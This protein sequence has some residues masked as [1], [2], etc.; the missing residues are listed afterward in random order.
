[1][2]VQAQAPVAQFTA[3]RDSGCAPLVVNFADISTGNP[4]TWE[5]DFGNGNQSIL[6]NASAFF[7]EEREYTI[8]LIVRNANGVDTFRKIIK[9]FG[10]PSQIRFTPNDTSGCSPFAINFSATSN[11]GFGATSVRYDWRFG[12]GATAI[13]ANVAHTYTTNGTRN[14]FLRATNDKGCASNAPQQTRI[15]IGAGLIVNFRDSILQD[16]ALP[17]RAY[18]INE[19]QT[20]GNTFSWNLGNGILSNSIDTVSRLFTTAG[21]YD[22]KLVA[23]NGIGCKDSITRS[24]N[25]VAFATSINGPDSICAGSSASFSYTSNTTISSS[26]WRDGLLPNPANNVASFSRT[27]NTPGNYSI[28]LNVNYGSCSDQITKTLV[29]KPRPSVSWRVDGDS[30][31]CSAPLE[32]RFV[33]TSTSPGGMFY[34][35]S[36]GPSGATDIVQQPRYLYQ[37]TGNF[38]VSLT[39][40]NSFN[41]SATLTRANTVR[42]QAPTASIANTPAGGCAPF[43]FNA[44]SGVTTTAVD[45]IVRYSWDFGVPG[46]D[47]DTS[48]LRNPSFTYQ[49]SGNYTA[50]LTVFTQTGCSIRVTRN[51]SIGSKATFAIQ[52]TP[53]TSCPD[54]S[55][56]FQIVG[57]SAGVSGATPP[58]RYSW[59]FGDG[60]PLYAGTTNAFTNFNRTYSNT[61]A[62]M[63]SLTIISNNTC[64]SD[65]VKLDDSIR[66]TPPTAFLR[67]APRISIAPVNCDTSLKF[68]FIDSSILS[69][70]TIP[71]GPNSAVRWIFTPNDSITRSSAGDS[72]LFTFPQAGNYNVRLKAFNDVNGGGCVD[73]LSTIVRVADTSFSV[74]LSRNIV[75]KGDSTTIFVSHSNPIMVNSYRWEF[76]GVRPQTS[77]T[78][79]GANAVAPAIPSLGTTPVFVATTVRPNANNGA[80]AVISNLRYALPGIYT[81]RIISTDIYG[82]QLIDSVKLTVTGPTAAYTTNRPLQ[83]G[84]NGC[85]GDVTFTDASIPNGASVA[86]LT[87][88]LG[89]GDRV[90]QAATTIGGTQ[91][92]YNY[93]APGTYQTRLVVADINGCLDSTAIAPANN[94]RVLNLGLT[95]ARVFSIDS[96]SCPKTDSINLDGLTRSE[97]SPTSSQAGITRTWTWSVVNSPTPI[98]LR[99]GALTYNPNTPNVSS[100]NFFVPSAGDTGIYKFKLITSI[101][102]CL[103]SVEYDVIVKSPK[104][105]FSLSDS[106][107]NCPPLSVDFTDNSYY[108]RQWRWDFG[109]F[110]GTTSTTTGNASNVYLF[111]DT[112][113]AVLTVESPGGCLASDSARIR[114]GGTPVQMTASPL[115]GCAPLNNVTLTAIAGVPN[116]SYRWDF[117]DGV[118]TGFSPS[119]AIT[120]SY[121]R[122]GD[123]IPRVFV[124]DSSNN[125]IVTARNRIDIHAEFVQPGFRADRTT[126]CDSGIVV[127]TDTSISNAVARTNQW[128]IINRQGLVLAQGAGQSF[129]HNFRDTGL[130]SVRLITT[131]NDPRNPNVNGCTESVTY[132]SLVRVVTSP[133]PIITLN[134]T[135]LCRPAPFLF[136]G[137]LQ[138]SDTSFI[139]SWSWNFGNGGTSNLQNPPLQIFPDADTVANTLTVISRSGCSTTVAQQ[140]FVPSDDSL[141]V[142]FGATPLVLC[143]SGRVTFRDSSLISVP[144]TPSWKWFFSNNPADTS[145]IQNPTFNYTST[146]FY[147]V[148]LVVRTNKNCID[149]AIFNNYVK[150]VHTS[151]PVITLTDSVLCRPANFTFTGSTRDIGGQP[152]TSQIVQWF[153]N[154]GNGATSLDQNPTSQIFTV[155]GTFPNNLT[156]VNSSG[157]VDSVKR[158]VKVPLDDSLQ[159]FFRADR[160]IICDSG[161]INFTD[162][163]I[164]NIPGTFSYQWDFGDG[165]PVIATTTRSVS[166][167]YAAAGKYNVKLIVNSSI[168]C[169]DTI[170]KAD[171]IL[172]VK[173]RPN[174]SVADTIQCRPGNFTFRGDTIGYNIPAIDTFPIVSWN[175]QFGGNGA[176]STLRNPPTQVFPNSGRFLTTLTITN[177]I[178]CLTIDSQFVRVLDDDSLVVGF[179]ANPLRLC[180]TGTVNFVDTSLINIPGVISWEWNFGD[181]SPVNN[182]QNPSH[183]YAGVGSYNVKLKV[184]SS[185]PGCRD[186]VTYSDYIRVLGKPQPV[187][188]FTTNDSICF[189][190]TFGFTGGQLA[191]DTSTITNW[192]WSFGN[193]NTA[194]VQNPSNQLFN[195]VGSTTTR[196]TIT[197]LVGCVKDTT[198]TTTVMPLPA[199][200]INRD[201]TICRGDA[202]TLTAGGANTYIWAPGTSLSSTTIANPIASPTTDITYGVRGFTNFGCFSDTLV[203]VRVMQPYTLGVVQTLDSICAGTTTQ[204]AAF[205]APLYNWTPAVGLSASNIP[206]PIASPSLTTTYT[207]AGF[208][209]L[210]CFTQSQNVTVRVFQYPTV[211]AGADVI[212]SA[213][214]THQFNPTVSTDVVSYSW[215]P[216]TNLSN[217]TIANPIATAFDNIAYILTVTNDGNCTSSDTVRILV[218]CDNS[219]VF[220]PNTFSPNN[221]GINDIFFVR[222]KGLY[223]VSSLR[224]FNRWG[225]MVFEKRNV[226]P[227]NPADGWDGTI[228][229]KRPQSDAY[230]YVVEVQCTTGQTLKYTGTITLV[231]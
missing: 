37:T 63:P 186:S 195:T 76:V 30:V 83:N 42:I 77:S 51:V 38:T 228:N 107:S 159:A 98:T 137:S 219:N 58:I 53:R 68:Y 201:T 144:G 39:V 56:N 204:L 28:T 110:T 121:S 189:P 119:N 207:V 150:V 229:G 114:I 16:C 135:A 1:M 71:A 152:D 100:V 59:N 29:V 132:D 33:N 143:D 208:D 9:V 112:L 185:L 69:T 4:T 102:G 90:Q 177:N 197:N 67:T 193:G 23:T 127:F 49:N 65:I 97:F 130:Y 131:T 161:T 181:N 44:A 75:C 196:L 73:S 151:K 134:D 47:D 141:A 213:G 223:A 171:Y 62:Y 215:S 209:T 136:S 36:F 205:G 34:N 8:R 19:T 70:P 198:V 89:N 158:N 146:G 20:S 78:N 133:R 194:N 139:V 176:T 22:V 92:T 15:T 173:P 160:R 184:T 214:A 163:S 104:V 31:S 12:D 46:R 125:C 167:F 35:W 82:C 178:G 230:V 129:S 105:K 24:V 99:N 66:I 224:I 182:S 94:P 138:P 13:G 88:I 106:V 60:S 174:I 187:I 180:D 111:P 154:F 212:L 113:T 48:N 57:G 26:T 170:D 61:G 85:I 221:D 202:I 32:V 123:F 217:P 211:N 222:G 155:S 41:C 190:A 93:T 64:S 162:T 7:T 3:D 148:K 226:T 14:V 87:W 52:A 216:A 169:T 145:N 17:I 6:Q 225:Q 199:L 128:V 149:S 91:F 206:N 95:R 192:Q 231:N 45:N 84:G 43:L 147:T 165:T 5:W 81:I 115:A 157:C 218:N 142:N 220:I 172:V 11:P 54:R 203:R 25:I 227:N 40:R 10:A 109:D 108:V 2:R 50:A 156:I 86:Q 27:Y 120:H 166:H 175:W 116:L 103:D 72:L 191:S 126:L 96:L 74:R 80:P 188:T 140:V 210:N 117:G 164:L 79:T 179:R 118:T 124:F 21:L 168:G 18:F 101:F 55:I 153:W 122:G 200:T 183:F